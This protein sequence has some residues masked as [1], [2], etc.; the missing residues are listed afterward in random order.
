[1]QYTLL[2]GRP[3]PQGLYPLWPSMHQAHSPLLPPPPTL[4]SVDS[5]YPLQVPRIQVWSGGQPG[6]GVTY[7][8]CQPEEGQ[9]KSGPESEGPLKEIPRLERG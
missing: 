9:G 1:M 4:P 3:L 5:C 2:L 8:H 7:P 6:P